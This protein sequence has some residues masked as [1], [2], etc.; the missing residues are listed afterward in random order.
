MPAPVAGGLTAIGALLVLG[1]VPL[2]LLW[3]QKRVYAQGWFATLAKYTV[4]GSVYAVLLSFV[5][6]YAVL[7]GLS[8]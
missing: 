8:S 3:M 4:L 7:A 6:V 2:Y 1:L 5:L